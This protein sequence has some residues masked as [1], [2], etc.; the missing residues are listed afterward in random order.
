MNKK[1]MNFTKEYISGL[2]GADVDVIATDFVN[3]HFLKSEAELKSFFKKQITKKI[4]DYEKYEIWCLIRL[5]YQFKLIYSNVLEYQEEV[6]EIITGAFGK[7]T[8]IKYM[9]LKSNVKD[10]DLYGSKETEMSKEFMIYITE[11]LAEELKQSFFEF[12]LDDIFF[13]EGRADEILE[14]A[15]ILGVKREDAIVID[16]ETKR[17]AKEFKKQKDK[18]MKELI[19]KLQKNEKPQYEVIKEFNEK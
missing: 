4:S 14:Y 3:T 10:S 5:T 1:K 13:T 11:G 18:A 7:K 2:F 8:L 17:E 15:E 19:K 9:Q 6:T 12:F 16:I